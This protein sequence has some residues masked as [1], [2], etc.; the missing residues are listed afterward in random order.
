MVAPNWS[1]A[2]E[3]GESIKSKFV[4][5]VLRSLF[6][7]DRDGAKRTPLGDVVRTAI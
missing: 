4:T 5:S 3:P 6:L 7:S 1:L 2:N